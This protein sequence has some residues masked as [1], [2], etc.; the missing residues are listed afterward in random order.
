MN[1]TWSF[2]DH[3]P[4]TVQVETMRGHLS[5]RSPQVSGR[6]IAKEKDMIVFNTETT[7]SQL[8]AMNGYV[9]TMFQQLERN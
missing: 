2:G 9:D 7:L 4:G 3:K 5:K 1:V 8:E 6:L